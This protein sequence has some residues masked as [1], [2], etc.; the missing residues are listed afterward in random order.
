MIILSSDHTIKVWSLDG[1]SDYVGQPFNLK[2]KAAVAAHDKDINSLAVAPND[3]LVCS[4][5]QVSNIFLSSILFLL[6]FFL[7]GIVLNK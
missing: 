2:A 4:G 6:F 1:L 3:S 5:S 7:V